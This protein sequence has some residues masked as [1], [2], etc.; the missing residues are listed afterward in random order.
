ML[1]IG[2]MRLCIEASKCPKH[3]GIWFGQI[4]ECRG[5]Y[6]G[7]VL[8]WI[9]EVM[10]IKRTFRARGMMPASLRAHNVPA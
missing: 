7:K 6:D 3:G 10:T 9:Q 5:K 4:G 2:K 1:E 8:D